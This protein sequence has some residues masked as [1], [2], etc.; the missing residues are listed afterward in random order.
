MNREPTHMK[1]N[2]IPTTP[3]VINRDSARSCGRGNLLPRASDLRSNS[4]NSAGIGVFGYGSSWCAMTMHPC[5]SRPM[6]MRLA[7]DT[8]IPEV[9]T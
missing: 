6:S 3:L 7:Q 1:C 5:H 8:P 2:T 4:S 9:I